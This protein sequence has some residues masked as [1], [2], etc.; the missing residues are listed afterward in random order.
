MLKALQR[1]AAV[2]LLG[3][4]AE[5]ALVDQTLTDLPV[6][7]GSLYLCG[8]HGLGRSAML[9]YASLRAEALGFAVLRAT[10]ASSES[11]TPYSALNQALQPI[12]PYVARLSPPVRDALVGVADPSG[13]AFVSRGEISASLARLVRGLS[14]QRA[15]VVLVDDVERVDSAS[16]EVLLNV[17]GGRW[18]SGAAIIAA[19]QGQGGAGEWQVTSRHRLQPLTPEL[20]RAMI[21]LSY[22]ELPA[23]LVSAVVSASSGYPLA[24]DALASEASVDQQ[25]FGQNIAADR[26][27]LPGRVKERGFADLMRLS[28]QGQRRLLIA[29]LSP[30]GT[31]RV[32]LADFSPADQGAV[33]DA[34]LVT[35]GRD[36]TLAFPH[37]LARRVVIEHSDSGER[38][39]I[40]KLLAQDAALDE[41]ARISLAADATLAADGAVA[42]SVMAAATETLSEGHPGRAILEFLRA[43]T[44]A[45]SADQQG[46]TLARAAHLQAVIMGHLDG[47]DSLLRDAEDRLG[48]QSGLRA[49]TTDVVLRFF[50]GG[51]IDTSYRMLTDA[52]EYA[53]SSDVDTDAVVD[54]LE[55]LLGVCAY[56]GRHDYCERHLG[57][58][59]RLGI[60]DA[61]VIFKAMLYADPLNNAKAAGPELQERLTALPFV[62]DPLRAAHLAALGVIIPLSAQMRPALLRLALDAREGGP[63]V[64]GAVA[65]RTLS[66]HAF[67]NGEWDQA[68]RLA[69]E[70]VDISKAN[71]LLIYAT[72]SRLTTALV[73]AG[74]GDMATC[75][76]ICAAMVSWARPRGV[77]IVQRS[78][79]HVRTLAALAHCDYRAARQHAAPFF[80]ADFA[81]VDL[82]HLMDPVEVAVLND[83][84]DL[85]QAVAATYQRSDVE[86]ASPHAQLLVAGARAFC[87][88][89]LDTGLYEEALALPAAS[90]FWFDRARIELRYGQ[91]LRRNR[92]PVGARRHLEVALDLFESMGADPWADQARA[93][94]RATN[95]TKFM[96]ADAAQALLTAQEG[97]VA[98]LAAKGLSNA[99][100]GERLQISTRTVGAHLH[101]VFGKTGLKNRAMLAAALSRRDTSIVAL[102]PLEI[103]RE[104]GL[105]IEAAQRPARSVRHE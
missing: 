35:V 52:L 71:D 70:A 65:M 40:H 82:L 44:L 10:G 84:Y 99:E 85:A 81:P 42:R 28:P 39:A 13:G 74:R 78:V 91:R 68:T 72:V 53:A 48:G 36:G 5:T 95:P 24:L 79:A 63:V 98:E 76:A 43:A 18:Q 54:T 51:D 50:R 22:P 49:I 88:D 67:L 11:E 92:Q 30:P 41:R 57:L 62:Q 89:P 26:L 27:P 101:H 73:A 77:G 9:E 15:L 103:G 96:P 64:L 102:A 97:R 66:V 29:A 87:A 61:G 31:A 55:A 34:S 8:E 75:N 86:V 47:A 21:A 23:S 46:T 17:F 37:Q 12:Y 93:E 19:G 25:R 80:E 2:A 60:T 14:A 56:S 33:R 69:D 45:P 104:V 59:R 16:V 1:T 83:D 90:E 20:A 38:R 32:V 58:V 7:G 100:I 6:R 94:L 105:G 4:E 3:R